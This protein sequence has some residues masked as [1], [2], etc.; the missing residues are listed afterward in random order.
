MVDI[1]RTYLGKAYLKKLESKTYG[2]FRNLMMETDEPADVMGTM[3]AEKIKELGPLKVLREAE[4]GEE[5]LVVLRTH[6]PVENRELS[7]VELDP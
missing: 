5:K 4:K 1:N 2:L 6:D 7:L 3:K